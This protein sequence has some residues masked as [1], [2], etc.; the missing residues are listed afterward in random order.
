LVKRWEHV[1]ASKF[2]SFVVPSGNNMAPIHRWFHLKE[3]YSRHLLPVLLDE[4]KLTQQDE[5]AIGDP[6]LGSGTTL[7]SA[8]DHASA[9]SG[10]KIR[11]IGYE[12]NP[13]LHLISE[14]KLLAATQPPPGLAQTLSKVQ[15]AVSQVTVSPQD[16]PALSTFHNADYFPEGHVW[17]LTRIRKAIEGVVDDTG[18]KL[19]AY[20]C[21]VMSVAPAGR[22]R[23]D[24]RTLRREA[25]EPIRPL[26]AFEAACKRVLH[27][28][29]TYARRP[30]AAVHLDARNESCLESE[31]TQGPAQELDLILF[32]P[33]YPNNID[34]TEVYKTELWA[35]GKISTPEAFR[36]QRLLTVRSHPSV[37]FD[38]SLSYLSD[39]AQREVQSLIDPILNAIPT[40][41][42]YRAQME[43]TVVGYADDMYSCLKACQH[44]LK[45]GGFCV[46]VVGNSVHGTREEPVL[47]A[48]DILMAA[49]AELAGLEVVSIRV[50]RT[51]PRRKIVSDLVRESVVVLRK[52]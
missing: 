11:G 16:V 52:G 45:S 10:T 22:L 26:L 32:S 43:R 15:D 24:G 18:A 1:H 47:I 49:L 42:R 19:L 12:V 8:V 48:G 23:R 21:L 31:W 30:P 35:L 25:R 36:A 40:N 17:E 41:S 38:R 6:F 7:L 2:E 9:S 51:L 5:L 28:I 37:K 27:D 20:L 3:A 44:Q 33:P 46:Y 39:P 4:L 29:S 14:A 50:A 13:A 34:Y